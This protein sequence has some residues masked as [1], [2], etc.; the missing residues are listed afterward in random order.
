VNLS[1][2]SHASNKKSMRRLLKQILWVQIFNRLER[3]YWNRG[4]TFILKKPIFVLK[5][6]EE[7]YPI[8]KITISPFSSW[9]FQ[10][11]WIQHFENLFSKLWKNSQM[12]S[13]AMFRKTNNYT[14]KRFLLN[15]NSFLTIKFCVW[16]HAKP[17]WV[18][19]QTKI[20][21]SNHKQIER[22]QE[23]KPQHQKPK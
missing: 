8:S 4:K 12:F 5:R 18:I 2:C 9:H 14:Y 17:I 16:L 21:S 1:I 7:K 15:W 20:K 11:C 3:K 19:C 13:F 10:K 6:G 23:N 22:N